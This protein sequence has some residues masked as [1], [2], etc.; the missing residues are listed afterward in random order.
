MLSAESLKAGDPITATV[1]VT[2][3][4]IMASDEVVEAYLKN[5]AS[6]RA[7]SLSRRV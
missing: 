7:P 3:A 5:T 4:G 2:N 6:R 1:I